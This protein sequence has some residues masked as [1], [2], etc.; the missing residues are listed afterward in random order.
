MDGTQKP[1]SIPVTLIS[2]FDNT[3]KRKALKVIARSTNQRIAAVISSDCTYDLKSTD[4][5]S[6]L[7]LSGDDF[8]EAQMGC[9]FHW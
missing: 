6:Q 5:E 7:G 8:V 3:T 9:I 2:G 4:F 1:K